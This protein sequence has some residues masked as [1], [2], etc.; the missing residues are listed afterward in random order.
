MGRLAG[1][2][3]VSDLLGRDDLIPLDIATYVTCLDLGPWGGLYTEG[4]DRRVASTGP[5]VK[6]VKQTINR[7]RIYPPRSGD[8]RA[9]LDAAAP[10]IQ[11]PPPV[12]AAG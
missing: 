2:N 8:R 12:R 3:A 7:A 4:W 11:T 5:E 9:I 10:V 1:H 6:T